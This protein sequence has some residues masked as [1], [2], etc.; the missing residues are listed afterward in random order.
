ML[1]EKAILEDPR[2][3]PSSHELYRELL[4]LVNYTGL[5]M[6]KFWYVVHPLDFILV[7][8][9]MELDVVK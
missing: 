3:P 6:Q 5:V 9:Y 1:R 4:N 7:L 2:Y 8:N